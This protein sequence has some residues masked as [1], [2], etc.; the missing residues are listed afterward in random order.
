MQ[1]FHLDYEQAM[2]TPAEVVARWQLVKEYDATRED[3]ENKRA[4]RAQRDKLE[5]E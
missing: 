1:E 2:N 3:I 5:E 4:N